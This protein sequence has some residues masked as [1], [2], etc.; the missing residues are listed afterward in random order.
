MKT[1]FQRKERLNLK[2]ID[3]IAYQGDS[4]VLRKTNFKSYRWDTE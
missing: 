1:S 3:E 2:G 4:F